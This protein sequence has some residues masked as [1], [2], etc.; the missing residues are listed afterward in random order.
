MTEKQNDTATL[1]KTIFYKDKYTSYDL[2]IPLPD[3]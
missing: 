1:E 3:I 2:A